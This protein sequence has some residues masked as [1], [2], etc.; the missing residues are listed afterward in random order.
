MLNEGKLSNILPVAPKAGQAVLFRGQDEE[1]IPAT[2]HHLPCHDLFKNLA[3]RSLRPFPSAI[4]TPPIVPP[5]VPWHPGPQSRLRLGTTGGLGHHIH[6]I[7][8]RW[9]VTLFT[10]DP[11]PPGRSSSLHLSA[12]RSDDPAA[13]GS[14]QSPRSPCTAAPQVVVFANVG[15]L[16]GSLLGR[17]PC[18]SKWLEESH[19]TRGPQGPLGFC[20]QA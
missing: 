12:P 13:L 5:Q 14:Q 6:L 15:G 4:P 20:S 1:T 2:C 9:V 7:L 3:S 11:V 18:G 8:G 17:G 19:A 10:A 16:H